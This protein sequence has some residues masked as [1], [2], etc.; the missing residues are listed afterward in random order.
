MA[1]RYRLHARVEERVERFPRFT[2]NGALLAEVELVEERLV[3]DA[4]Q[5]VIDAHVQL[6]AVSGQCEAVIKVGA[7]Q[8]V[9][10]VTGFDLCFE[11]RESSPDAILL[12]LEQIERH[13][14][15]IVS[16]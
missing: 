2:D 16:L 12:R 10:H 6:V 8:F 13:R 1:G 14:P 9:L 15:R 5:R 3:G 7:C 4:P 11:K